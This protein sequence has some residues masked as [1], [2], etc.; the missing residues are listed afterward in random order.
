MMPFLEVAERILTRSIYAVTFLSLGFL[1]HECGHYV[2]GK[3]FGGQPY[4]SEYWLV[5][6]STT[7]FDAPKEMKDWQVRLTAGFV[8]LFPV[9]LLI[10]AWHRIL[11]L[12]LVGLAGSVISATDLLGAYHPAAWKKLADGEPI[13]VE[14][15]T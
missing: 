8:L 10:A 7:T 5:L 4:F 15:V 12:V 9:L 14:D 11:P 1:I 3:T 2:F 6:P 13:S